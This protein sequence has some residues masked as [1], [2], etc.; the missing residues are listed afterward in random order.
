M[1]TRVVL[2]CAAIVLTGVWILSS[3]ALAFR[4]LILNV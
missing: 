3:P 2:V 1:Q 4:G